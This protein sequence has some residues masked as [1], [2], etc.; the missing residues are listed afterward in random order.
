[1]S[2]ILEILQIGHPVLR[3]TSAPLQRIDDSVRALLAAMKT[4][5]AQGGIGLAAPQ[6]GYPVRLVTIDIPPE[7]D[8]TTFITVNGEPKTLADIMPLDFVNPIIEPYGPQELFTE[9]CLS[10]QEVYEPVSRPTHVKVRMNL[11]DGTP[12]TLDCNGLLA[13]C[14]QHECDH[15]EGILFTDLI[16]KR[17]DQETQAS[18]DAQPP[19]A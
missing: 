7:E 11:M 19:Q 12:I 1:M 4:T 8:S 14:L 6:V 2:Q 5:L 15:L 9:G 16:A 13:R 10:I 17:G 3:Q 18:Q